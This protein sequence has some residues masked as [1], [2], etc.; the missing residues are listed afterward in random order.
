MDLQNEA[1]CQRNEIKQLSEETQEAFI[2]SAATHRYTDDVFLP[3][4]KVKELASLKKVKRVLKQTGLQGWEELSNF[5]NSRARKLFLILILMFDD[6]GTKLEGL[7]RCRDRDWD[8]NSLPIPINLEKSATVSLETPKA[9]ISTR[10]PL[11]DDWEKHHRIAFCTYWQ[12]SMLAPVFTMEKFFYEFETSHVLPFIAK[13]MSERKSDGFFGEVTRW[14]IHKTHIDKMFWDAEDPETGGVPVAIKKARHD[15]LPDFFDKERM[16]AEA[17][18]RMTLPHLIKS[19]AAYTIGGGDKYI[20]LPW[21]NGGTLEDYWGRYETNSQSPENLNWLLNQFIGLFGTLRMCHEANNLV[22]GDLKPDNILWFKAN[23]DNDRGVLK[24]A[25]LG[26]ATFHSLNHPTQQRKDLFMR[27]RTPS[28]AT[29]EKAT[30]SRQYD[31]WSMGC[32]LLEQ[33]ALLIYGRE[34]LDELR[35]E[36]R[37]FWECPAHGFYSVHRYVIAFMK[38]TDHL[39]E[40]NHCFKALLRLVR[41]RLLVVPISAE[42][43]SCPGKRERAAGVCDELIVIHKSCSN[44]KN[45]SRL[46]PLRLEFPSAMIHENRSQ[47]PAEVFQV[48]DQRLEPPKQQ[49][50]STLPHHDKSLDF[51]ENE[52]G[53][54]VLVRAP[55]EKLQPESLNTNESRVRQNEQQSNKLNDDWISYPNTEFV[56]TFFKSIDWKAVRPIKQAGRQALCLACRAITSAE[57]LFASECDLS[58]LQTTSQTCDLCRLVMQELNVKNYWPPEEVKLRQ[59]GGLVGIQDGPNLLSLY[60]EPELHGAQ[61]GLPKLLP[62]AKSDQFTLMKHWIRVCDSNHKACRRSDD[63]KKAPLPMPT[64]LIEVGETI[65]LINSTSLKPSQYLAL[66]HC[67][68]PLM[69]SEKF[70]TYKRNIEQHLTSIDFKRLPKT[71]R[72]AITVDRGLGINYI[73]IDSL[74]IIQ[75][76]MDDWKTEAAQMER[77]F[78]GAYCTIAASSAKS[79]LEGF[80]SRKE[81]RSYVTLNLE[82]QRVLYVCPFIDDF[83]GDVELGELSSRGWV[84]QERALSRRSIHFTS[85]Q[86]Y[87]ECGHGVQCETLARLHNSKAEFLGDAN[88]P[89]SALNYYRDGRQ[90]LI[91]DLYERYSRLAFSKPAD[92]SMAIL[93]LQERLSQSFH[94]PA[95]YGCFSAYFARGLLWKSS[96]VHFMRSIPDCPVPSWS[97]F[98][99]QGPIKYMSYQFDWISWTTNEFENPFRKTKRKDP[100][101]FGKLSILRGHAKKLNITKA[102]MIVLVTFDTTQEYEP[103]RLRGAYKQPDEIPVLRLEHFEE[104]CSITF[105]FKEYMKATHGNRDEHQRAATEKIRARTYG[106][107][108]ML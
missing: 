105:Q 26:I 25:D 7:K 90:L 1:N 58:S 42:Y 29:S 82:N 24:I 20:M 108:E 77:V 56:T 23:N 73:W 76:D 106:L 41:D 103:G 36:T 27:T 104:V 59:D 91:Q 45:R 61:L 94:T 78:S 21:A 71:F 38:T 15:D 75:D 16:N 11:F 79:S 51:T 80:L 98:G 30:R 99:K 62:S 4:H 37:H 2:K 81:E 93:G 9:S 8:D 64:R 12:W 65:R 84:L 50:K 22:H 40:G 92:R 6:D 52:E 31:I 5:I 46:T 55:T 87:W 48:G 95:A 18:Q 63:D 68:G 34:T 19:I 39:L 100:E 43:K 101:D 28:G 96:E 32:V 66:S 44:P 3:D 17:A 74:C 97:W 35:R 107:R 33:L 86:V 67:W 88:F 83:H 54:K 70:C 102:E 14:E 53:P 13:D 72:D 89:R 60:H 49:L 47:V 85:N 69:E 57:Q 10:C